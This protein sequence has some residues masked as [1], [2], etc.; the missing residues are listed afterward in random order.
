MNLDELQSVRERERQTDSLQEL[1][2][3]FYADAG[4]FV[5]NLRERREQAAER[6]GS[7]FD[8]PE[9]DRLN[10]E[11][12]A[13]EETVEAI[14][15]K[16][17]GKLVKA[18]SLA[19]AGMS[20]RT[21]GMTVEEQQLFE[22]LVEDIE[23]NRQ[24]VLDILTGEETHTE[25]AS[26]EDTTVSSEP[27]ER[28]VPSTADDGPTSAGADSHRERDG[29]S[30]DSEAMGGSGQSRGAPGADDTTDVSAGPGSEA[31]EHDEQRG[32]G[33]NGGV[34]PGG[35]H[36]RETVRIT[37]DVGAFLGVDQREYD[38]SEDDVVQL[39]AQ[40]ADPLVERDVAERLE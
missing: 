4:E 29:E 15:E 10:N 25:S 36:D 30:V 12:E 20:A 33:D 24:Y 38:L 16:R 26:D 6:A 32:D 40:N 21:E 22:T 14:Y 31:T 27:S 1:R 3:T 19:A 8:A 7:P 13:A 11:I 23:S 35:S 5:R 18:A 28:D 37:S 9:V 34:V 39:P 17:L 2:E